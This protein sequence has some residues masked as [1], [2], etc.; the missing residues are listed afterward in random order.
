MN[1]Q[2]HI[3]EFGQDLINPHISNLSEMV[4]LEREK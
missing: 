2:S 1:P 4:M 3:Q